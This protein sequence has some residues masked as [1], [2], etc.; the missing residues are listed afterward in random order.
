[1]S[2]DAVKQ[3]EVQSSTGK[4][5]AVLDGI[6]GIAILMVVA[7]HTIYVN[8]E[9]GPLQQAFM[10]VIQ[11]GWMGVQV[12]FVLSGFLISY[13]LFRG[14]AGDSNFWYQ[15]GYTR[16]RVG[17]ILPPFYLA[18]ILISLAYVPGFSDPAFRN[19]A[20]Q[21][22][23]GLP[24]FIQNDV[25]P[26]NSY[27]SLIV[28]AH[29][30]FVLPL[31]FFFTRGLKP[32]STA[33]LLFCVL[34]LVPFFVRHFTWPEPG[35]PKLVMSFLMN[36]FPGALDF[37]GWGVLFAGIFVA[38]SA[39]HDLRALGWFGPVGL[40]LMAMTLGLYAFWSN[41]LGIHHYPQRWAVEVFHLL[42][43]VAT[44]FMLFF[45]FDP[46]GGIT[47]LLAHPALRFTGIISYEWFL[48]HMPFVLT[49]NHLIGSAQGSLM[50]YLLK[51]VVP[52]ALSYGFSVLVYRYF[53]LPLMNRIR[54][55][56]PARAKQ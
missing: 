14:R 4:H 37:F 39:N 29:F 41:T 28:E 50:Y 15:K 13:P 32:A 22:A 26:F 16:R 23:L 52:L 31:L 25:A 49:A 36:R 54:G 9:A 47:R 19:A 53:S 40:V 27:W 12:F 55:R 5:F 8:P 30:Y 21:W 46:D 45:V 17:K 2:G 33:A 42:P 24:N 51:T 11:T 20:W 48:F 38:L 3:W 1:M 10:N 6:R 34:F 43:G 7:F 56:M 18:I 44:F 35:T